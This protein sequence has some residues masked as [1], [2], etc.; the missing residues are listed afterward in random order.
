MRAL[1]LALLVPLC[2]CG[3]IGATSVINDAEV[4]VARAHAAEGDKYAI[5]ETTAADLY[6]QKAREEQGA[7]QY[8]NA[9]DLGKRSVE[10]ADADRHL[11]A[12]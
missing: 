5:Y 7:A 3:P 11:L 2:G 4:A 10:L 9:M 8:G 6:L 1:A 12:N